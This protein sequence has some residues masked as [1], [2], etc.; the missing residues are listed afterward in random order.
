T[1]DDTHLVHVVR[2]ALRDQLKTPDVWAGL[3]RL[4][5]SERDGRDIADVATG[6]HTTQA[7]AFLLTHLKRAA[8]PTENHLRYVHHV[9]RYGSP[10]LTNEVLALG[11]SERRAPAERLEV[12][13]AVQQGAQE[14]GGSLDEPAR[15]LAARL[16]GELLAS[17]RPNDVALG[18]D[19][20]RD[21]G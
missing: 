12:L 7:A 11:G 20:V 10:E 3:E 21:F 1:P 19:V 15:R 2:M 6:V 8:D 16:A 13:E 9:A 17:N 4:G 14:R 18:I 5:L